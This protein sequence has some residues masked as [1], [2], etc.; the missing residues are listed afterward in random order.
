MHIAGNTLDA[1]IGIIYVVKGASEMVTEN[2]LRPQLYGCDKGTVRGR[3]SSSH[4]E[5]LYS[6]MF[7]SK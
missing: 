2:Q 3:C 7:S 5:N 1:N 6:N 4:I